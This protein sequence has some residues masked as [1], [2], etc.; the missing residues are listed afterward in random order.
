MEKDQ[1]PQHD[2][3]LLDGVREVQYA[4]D[5]SGRYVQV[6]STGWDPK[7]A[8][9]LQ[10]HAMV[11][12]RVEA[13]R[14]RALAGETS[15]LEFHMERCM[16]DPGLLAEYA[17]LSARTVKRH[18]TPRGFAAASPAELEAYARAL[19]VAVAE[20]RQVPAAP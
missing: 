5:E 15:P 19:D 4:V 17:G 7:N 16:M 1:V 3:G 10:A 13:A 8:A 6:R 11:Q 20:L 12:A 14:R 18:L 2:A 9:L